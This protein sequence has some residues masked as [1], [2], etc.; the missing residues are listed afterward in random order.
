MHYRFGMS[1]EVLYLLRKDGPSPALR[2]LDDVVLLADAKTL[3]GNQVAA[4][5]EGTVVGVWDGGATIAV[6]FSE[7]EG[8]IVA[9]PAASLRLVGRSAP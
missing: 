7:P 1:V 8:A 2:E 5:A 3:D 6:E 9:V 4:G